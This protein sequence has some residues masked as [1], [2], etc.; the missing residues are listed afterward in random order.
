MQTWDGEWKPAPWET[1]RR[2]R[3]LG[4]AGRLDRQL[5]EAA[6]AAARTEA[7]LAAALRAEVQAAVAAAADSAALFARLVD[8]HSQLAYLPRLPLPAGIAGLMRDLLGPD[9]DDHV[10]VAG[11]P[12]LPWPPLE[13]ASSRPVAV[14]PLA[15]ARDPLMWPL[16][17]VQGAAVAGQPERVAGLQQ[18]LGPALAFARAAALCFADEGA[19]RAAWEAGAQGLAQ[20]P[21]DKASTIRQLA[22]TLADGVLISGCRRGGRPDPG[23]PIYD[24]LAVVRD[25]PAE[26][27]EI[28][29]AGWVHWASRT[30]AEL[31][32]LAEQVRGH[33]GGHGPDGGQD[34]W[35]RLRGLVDGL[36]DL[37]CRS[38]D[39][40]AIHRFYAAE[41]AMG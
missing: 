12:A 38:L 27:A 1:V 29:L 36:D 32:E 16:V 6:G 30:A 31:V 14:I 3:V 40:A 15:E 34:P 4:L 37:L 11:V 39:V 19:A 35:W 20:L 8:V 2:A 41:G 23:A 22:A 10:V 26:P 24:Q 9:W 18:N 33:D 25:E 13:A 17:A 5:Q 21:A 7:R 28:L